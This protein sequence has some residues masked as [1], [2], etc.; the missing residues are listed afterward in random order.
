MTDDE[1][2]E[3]EKALNRYHQDMLGFEVKPIEERA[4][5][6][7][8]DEATKSE[9]TRL[10]KDLRAMWEEAKKQ[11]DDYT[12]EEVEGKKYIVIAKSRGLIMYFERKLRALEG[13][14]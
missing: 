9:R 10:L 2:K 3:Y 8:W 12:E 11:R 14:K 4:F 13:K 7:G 1:K 6:Q 5:R